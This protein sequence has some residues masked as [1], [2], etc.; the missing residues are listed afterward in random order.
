MIPPT[1][2]FLG[3]PFDG[4]ATLGWPGA[5]YAP[6]EIRHNLSW[7]K[8]RVEDGHIYWIDRDE[9]V[10]FSPERLGDAGDVA[11]VPHD[12]MA[13]LAACRRAVA[14]LASGGRRPETGGRRR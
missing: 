3:V 10:P 2:A 1:Y 6:D 7:M 4:G 14:A 9:V 11:V 5:R 12:L 13:T 8:M